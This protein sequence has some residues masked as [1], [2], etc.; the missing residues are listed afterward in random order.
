[1]KNIEIEAVQNRRNMNIHSYSIK[2][3]RNNFVT[4][5]HLYGSLNYESS[6]MRNNRYILKDNA[7]YRSRFVIIIT[8]KKIKRT[9]RNY[10]TLR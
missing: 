10:R 2:L 3:P 9:M 4:F 1:M 5:L 7:R 6:S 8:K